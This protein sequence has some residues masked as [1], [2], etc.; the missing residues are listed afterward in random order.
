M[1]RMAFRIWMT[2]MEPKASPTMQPTR[3]A[4]SSA[5]W[6]RGSSGGISSAAARSSA[7]WAEAG[8]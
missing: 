7:P 5:T 8:S 6:N 3:P 2:T 4:D 1:L